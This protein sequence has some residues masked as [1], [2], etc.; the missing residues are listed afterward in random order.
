MFLGDCLQLTL[1]IIWGKF[2]DFCKPQSNEVRARFDL[3]TTFWQGNRSVDEWYNVVQAQ[4]NL[5]KYPPE[6]AKI[7][8]RDIFWFSCMMKSLFP[9][10]SVM[11]V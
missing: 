1:E 5:A 7:L 6:T 2:E 8:Q 4:V 3:L 10:P 9:R 11:E